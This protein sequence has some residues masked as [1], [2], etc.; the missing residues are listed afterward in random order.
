MEF[1][2]REKELDELNKLYCEDAF[3]LFVLYGRRRVGKTTLLNEF[4]KGKRAIFYSAEQSNRKLNLEKFSER[5]FEYY[6]ESMLEPFSSWTNAISYIDNRQQNERLIL[7]LDEFPYLVR[8]DRA[9]LS[10]LQHLI[11]H[12][13][14]TG[15]L[16]IILCGS[17]MGFME[18]EVLGAKSPLFGRRTAQLHMKTFDY[19]TAAS[20]MQGYTNEEKLMLYGAFGGTP[21]YLNQIRAGESFEENVRRAYLNVTAYLYEEPLLLLRQEVQEVGVY[22][23]VIEAI[24]GGASKSNEISTKIGEESA[25]CLKYINALCELGILYK[26][27]P[28]GEKQPSRK[29]LYGI[30]DFMFR[31]WYRYVFP[32]RT[33]V[34]TGADEVIWKK[35]IEGNYS[36]YMGIVFEKVCGDYLLRKNALGELPILFT[37]IGRWWGSSSD[38]ADK[39][40]VEIDLVAKDGTDYMFCECKWK[41]EKTDLAVLKRLQEKADVFS[42]KRNRSFFVLF[43][44]SGFTD[45]VL[46]EAEKNPSVVLVGLDDLFL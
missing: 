34:E 13:L 38:A 12:T 46:E 17:Y 41:N 11:D 30:S 27:A 2:G 1:I 16:F 5:V 6:G 20:F 42:K 40:Q 28:F 3:Q 33:L 23:A 25:K 37:D 44:K 22:S 4:C 43:S 24:A 31:F 10:E 15:R 35:R 19:K 32:N 21:L 8:K 45:A 39:N 36:E 26:E 18:K 29:T 14:Q 9:L 7:V